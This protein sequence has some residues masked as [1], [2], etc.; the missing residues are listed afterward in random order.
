MQ[1]GVNLLAH[2]GAIN[3]CLA[4]INGRADLNME[5][6]RLQVK[7]QGRQV[8]L[9]PQFVFVHEGSMA[10]TPQLLPQIIDFS[11]WRSYFNRV[12]P[13]AT[14]KLK[15]K[16]YCLNNDVRTP[17]LWPRATDVTATAI[18]K[19]SRSSFAK[20]ISAPQTPAM[21]RSGRS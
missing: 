16:E 14:D 9:E 15:F 20:N 17:Q 5:T 6:L 19:R 4:K 21:L 10:F 3:E 8:E 18:L 12:W 11:G 2:I 7:A 1:H 13:L